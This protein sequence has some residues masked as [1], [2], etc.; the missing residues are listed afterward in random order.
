MKNP[1]MTRTSNETRRGTIGPE[2]VDED[3][4]MSRRNMVRTEELDII[5]C[6]IG[7]KVV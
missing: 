1:T 3:V 7:D 4:D 5:L 2:V 6:F